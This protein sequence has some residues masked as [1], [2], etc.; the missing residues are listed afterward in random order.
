MMR[1]HYKAVVY[2]DQKSGASH[3]V[4]LSKSSFLA[5]FHVFPSHME[6]KQKSAKHLM[7]FYQ[8]LDVTLKRWLAP[9]HW[10]TPRENVA[11]S[12]FKNAGKDDFNQQTAC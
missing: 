12:K 6:K 8:H 9:K 5:F 11:V 10:S 4:H 7:G 3:A 1:H 2:F